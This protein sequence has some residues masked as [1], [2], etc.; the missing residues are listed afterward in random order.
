MQTPSVQLQPASSWPE[1]IQRYVEY[2]QTPRWRGK[3]WN[4]DGTHTADSLSAAQALRLQR[5]LLA[6]VNPLLENG[7][8]QAKATPE[9][10]LTVKEAFGYVGRRFDECP[11]SLWHLWRAM[12]FNRDGYACVY[13]GRATAEVQ[14]QEG[15]GLR[16]E[17]DHAVPRAQQGDECDDFDGRNIV[18]ACRSCNVLKGQMEGSRFR[19]ELESLARAVLGK[20]AAP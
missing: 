3:T 20:K 15:R 12:V 14:A 4:T 18:T 6:A 13:C 8:L 7:V 19:T 17:L 5:S 11:R 16:F 10:I 9:D 2:M 1:L